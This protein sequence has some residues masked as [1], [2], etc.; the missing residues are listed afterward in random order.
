MDQEFAIDENEL[1]TTNSYLNSGAVFNASPL[2]R[3]NN[4]ESIDERNISTTSSF[5]NSANLFSNGTSHLSNNYEATETVNKT[6]ASSQPSNRS[7]PC[8][9]YGPY[10]KPNPKK[11][12]EI[13]F[14]K[15]LFLDDFNKQCV[16][17]ANIIIG[18]LRE[19]KSSE[20]FILIR[21][22][23]GHVGVYKGGN[24][25]IDLEACWLLNL[26]KDV[27]KTNEGVELPT[28]PSLSNKIKFALAEGRHVPIQHIILGLH[29]AQFNTD[30]KEYPYEFTNKI[31]VSFVQKINRSDVLRAINVHSLF[32]G[33]SFPLIAIQ[34]SSI[35]EYLWQ[36]MFKEKHSALAGMEL[37]N[38][39]FFN[40]TCYLGK[41]IL[42][43][44]G[45][46]P[47]DIIEK[48]N[49]NY[50]NDH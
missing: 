10:A 47:L 37:Y 49:N 6:G 22:L 35:K 23:T 21:K 4:N 18:I 24:P 38:E 3:K 14:I 50:K 30:L 15:E 41:G 31:D 1:N 33:F 48:V 25:W 16:P 17:I 2:L 40:F 36:Y 5:L 11:N 28:E 32:L 19:F 7:N 20:K 42:I 9:T 46:I 45:H 27:S 12:E 34:L 29:L 44:L 43:P 26:H 13:S 8:E 39:I